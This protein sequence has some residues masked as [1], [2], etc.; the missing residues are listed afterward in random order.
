[1][2]LSRKHKKRR[3]LN[4]K[5]HG[6]TDRIMKEGICMSDLQKYKKKQLQDAELFGE[7][8]I[9]FHILETRDRRRE[10]GIGRLK[11]SSAVLP[12]RG[13]QRP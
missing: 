4:W 7:H 11:F 1:M 9:D 3:Q 8:A 13:I 2:V 6:N 5:K 12:R 10:S